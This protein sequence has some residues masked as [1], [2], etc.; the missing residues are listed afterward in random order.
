MSSKIK[1]SMETRSHVKSKLV[2]GRSKVSGQ[3]I[4]NVWIRE[5]ATVVGAS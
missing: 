2:I 3:S 1:D 5:H 4:P